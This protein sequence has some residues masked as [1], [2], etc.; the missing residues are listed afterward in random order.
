MCDSPEAGVI[1]IQTLKAYVN[2]TVTMAEQELMVLS[3]HIC[4][5]LVCKA[6]VHCNAE[7]S[8]AMGCSVSRGTCGHYFHT[9]CV[10]PWLERGRPNCP[11]CNEAWQEDRVIIF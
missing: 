3:C 11:L 4:R 2:A 1:P 10:K 9:H 8:P 5:E 7:L 6:C